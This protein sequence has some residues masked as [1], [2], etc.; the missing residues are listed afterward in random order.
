MYKKIKSLRQVSNLTG[1]PKSTI[2][3][4]NNQL[5]PK[6]TR[7]KKY[8]ESI[9]PAIID[10]V[11][12]ISMNNISFTIEE[13]KK[14]LEEK[15]V[16]CSY[17]LIRCV[18]RNHMK[19]SFK[20]NKYANQLNEERLK[21]QTEVFQSN[22]KE[23]Y[24][25]NSVIASIDEVG[26]CSR[27]LPLKSWSPVGKPNYIKNKL[28]TKNSKNRSTCACITSNCTINYRT[29]KKPYKSDTFLKFLKTL[30]L[31][32]QTIVLIDNV[33]FHHSKIIKKYAEQRHWNLLYTPPYSPW[34]NPIENIFAV[35]KN[36]YRKNKSIDD[37][38]NSIK[39]SAITNCIKSAIFK[40]KHESQLYINKN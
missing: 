25:E 18:L 34:F 30:D 12:I 10:A 4:W 40:I 16:F 23:L 19:F 6:L 20:K 26:F 29:Q 21:N 14:F 31:P 33:S 15:K 9:R 39:S 38:F 3:R 36:H 24:K 5:M 17:N 22:F 8:D 35:V 37:A 1:I 27:L 7:K 13:I 32:K 2:S 11:E 28:D